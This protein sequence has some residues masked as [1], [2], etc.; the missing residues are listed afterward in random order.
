MA[1]P[2]N[3]AV[4]PAARTAFRM[5][6]AAVTGLTTFSAIAATGWIASIAAGDYARKQDEKAAQA[7][8]A[9][10][11]AAQERATWLK[12]H[13]VV[14]VVQHRRPHRTVVRTVTVVAGVTPGRGGTISRTSAVSS[15]SSGTSGSGGTRATHTSS[16]GSSST[17][18][19]PPP[20]PPPP[21]PSSGS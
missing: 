19:Q 4:T 2:Q 12:A 8:A 10:K 17:P 9:A 21:A 6:S 20:P 7:E 11:R 15:G 3:R 14:R 16:G 18:A 13:P 1:A 5:A